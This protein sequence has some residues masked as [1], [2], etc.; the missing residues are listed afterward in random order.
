MF[1]KVDM[2]LN[3]SEF[4]TLKPGVSWQSPLVPFGPMVRRSSL[5]LIKG[6]G[7]KV[8]RW[9]AFRWSHGPTGSSGTTNASDQVP[10]HAFP[11]TQVRKKHAIQER[12][13]R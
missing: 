9:Q 4:E 6:R 12:E 3:V 8:D 10:G 13:A 11:P 1:L 2:R 7:V 5:G